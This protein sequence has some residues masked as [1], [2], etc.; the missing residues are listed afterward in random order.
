M[1][2]HIRMPPLLLILV[3]AWALPPPSALACAGA[4][5][6]GPPGAWYKLDPAQKKNELARQAKLLLERVERLRADVRKR[7][8]F[9]EALAPLAPGREGFALLEL[10]AL[11]T[12]E[13][14]EAL[15]GHYLTRDFSPELPAWAANL[16]H[17][18]YDSG[19]AKYTVKRDFRSLPP[20]HG[21]VHDVYRELAEALTH[22]G[23]LQ[24][25]WVNLSLA[26]V[27]EEVFV[28][29]MVLR[30]VDGA[31]FPTAAKPHIDVQSSYLAETIPIFGNA[32]GVWLGTESPI[33]EGPDGNP[34][35]RKPD[36]AP[37]PGVGV[38]QSGKDR[39]DAVPGVLGTWHW[40]PPGKRLVMIVV[41]QPVRTPADRQYR[42]ALREL[43]FGPSAAPAP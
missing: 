32:T 13:L 38:V 39:M 21:I 35:W 11:F 25:E 22:L 42:T 24:E 16:D 19:A 9:L 43:V 12:P 31:A 36:I 6:L 20:A 7:A 29:F 17:Y 1:R 15:R 40:G 18:F 10:G 37:E 2:F 30:W 5:L 41:L 26:A 3:L 27:Q 4:E 14:V 23:Q 34:T 8:A 28:S 33:V